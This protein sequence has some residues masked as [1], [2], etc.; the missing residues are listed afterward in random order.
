MIFIKNMNIQRKNNFI[1]KACNVHNNKYNYLLVDYK[2]TH[3]KVEIICPIHDS[4]FQRPA[5]HLQGDGCPFCCKNYKLNTKNFITKAAKVHNHEYD[6]SQVY[7]NG[8]KEKVKIICKKHG[9]FHQTPN[10]H[11]N[12]QGCPLCGNKKK[13][14]KRTTSLPQFI[15]QSTQIHSNKYDYSLVEYVNTHTKVKIICPDHGMFECT[16]NN[17]IFGASRCPS[18]AQRPYSKKAITW[19]EGIINKEKIFIQHAEN[20]GEY[21][22]PNTNYRA[23]GYC[24]KTNTIYEFN[25]DVYHENL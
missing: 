4:F 23:D 13:N 10:H 9:L 5:R 12:G 2:N 8:N 25:G 6:Y 1:Q 19:L 20:G 3:S 15:R 16:P 22:I 21:R 24:N 18:C 14:Q 11:L 17:H 7:Y